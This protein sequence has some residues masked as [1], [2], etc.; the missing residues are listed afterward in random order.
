MCR[1]VQKFFRILFFDH[2][3]KHK[4]YIKLHIKDERLSVDG[5]ALNFP[6]V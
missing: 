4:E 5:R 1:D 3:A 2:A 6:L